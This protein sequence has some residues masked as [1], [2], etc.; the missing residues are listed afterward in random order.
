MITKLKGDIS[1]TETHFQE[2]MSDIDKQIIAQEHM[3]ASNEAE[4]KRELA[5]KDKLAKEIALGKN[6]V[7]SGGVDPYKNISNEKTK[8]NFIK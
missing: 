7:K 4:I 8:R 1:K 5:L 3:L 6:N 2:K